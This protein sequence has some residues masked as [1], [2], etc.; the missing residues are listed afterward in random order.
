MR[1]LALEFLRKGHAERARLTVRPFTDDVGDLLSGTSRDEFLQIVRQ[2]VEL[3][4]RGQTRIQTALEH[5]VRDIRSEGPCLGAS[6]LLVTDGISRLTHNPLGEEK[7]H[8]FLLGDLFEETAGAGTVTTLKSWS[9]SFRRVWKSHFPEFLVPA[10]SDCESAMR[11]VQLLQA[12]RGED[13]SGT[14]GGRIDR[15]VKNVRFLVDEFKRSLG[16]RAAI[17]A[18]VRALEEQLERRGKCAED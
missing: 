5:A 1:G 16:K 7:L 2:V 14:R 9:Q 17:P 10:W 12:D 6:I 8:T 3:P 15:A 4:N 13:A 18:E 11:F